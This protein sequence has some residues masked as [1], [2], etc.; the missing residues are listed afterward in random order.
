[1]PCEPTFLAIILSRTQVKLN[2]SVIRILFL[3]IYIEKK[4]Y[5]MTNYIVY[6]KRKK[7]SLF[8]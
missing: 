4:P 2:V 1:M 6:E 7:C 5:T 3:Q 8:D